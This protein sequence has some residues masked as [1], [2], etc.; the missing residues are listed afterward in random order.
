MRLGSDHG[1]D[2]GK[3]VSAFAVSMEHTIGGGDELKQVGMVE[4][5]LTTERIEK[6]HQGIRIDSESVEEMKMARVGPFY[7][8]TS[9]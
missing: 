6:V 5:F 9:M 1:R 3:L 7:Q 4:V 2:G 8:S